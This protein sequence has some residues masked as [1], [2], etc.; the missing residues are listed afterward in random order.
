MPEHVVV[1]R[2][3]DIAEGSRAVVDIEGEE[4]GIFRVGG[5]LVAYGNYCAHAGGPVCQG[6]VIRRVEERLDEAK[7]SLG[8]AFSE[9]LHVVCPWHGYEYNL[10]TGAH[11]ADPTI[12]LRGYRVFERDGD[13]VVEL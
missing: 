2:G 9:D 7:R 6:M 12:R 4:I 3:D 5:D 8:D 11:P 10:R 13:V 1:A